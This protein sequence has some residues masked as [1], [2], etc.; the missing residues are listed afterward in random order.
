ML[1][2]ELIIGGH[3]KQESSNRRNASYCRGDRG[4]GK[5]G[6]Y[7]QLPDED[8]VGYTLTSEKMVESVGEGLCSAVD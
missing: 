5:L 4:P 7:G 1:S 6:N 3:R 2:G 8:G